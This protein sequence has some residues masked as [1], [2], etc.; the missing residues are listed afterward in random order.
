MAAVWILRSL[1]RLGLH[2]AVAVAVAVALAAVQAPLRDGTFVHGLWVSCYV[3]GFLY[4]MLGAVGGSSFGRVLD[5]R[6]QAAS[7][8]RIPGAAAWSALVAAGE[9]EPQLT[10]TAVLLLAGGVVIALGAL[11]QVG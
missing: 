5:A 8:G 9:G 1:L 6:T 11:L 10:V 7:L 2:V 4:A 3:V